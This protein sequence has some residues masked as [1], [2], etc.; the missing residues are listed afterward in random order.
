MMVTPV[1]LPPGCPRLATSRPPAASALLAIT[2][3]MVEV[4]RMAARMATVTSATMT[5]GV[6]RTSSVANVD[7]WSSWPSW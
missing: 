7:R 6:R 4:A 1:T 2:I 3:G 5:S